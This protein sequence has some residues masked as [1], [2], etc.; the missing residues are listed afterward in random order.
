MNQFIK[1]VLFICRVIYVISSETILY[2]IFRDYSNFI[3][4]ITRNLAA[5]NI[6]YVKVFQAFASNNC[7]IDDETNNQLLKFTDNAPW[8]MDD[9]NLRDINSI[10]YENNLRFNT[11]TELP[12]NTGMISLVFKLYNKDTN[13]PVILK[14]KR[15]QIEEKLIDAICNLQTFMYLLSFFPII[16]K[17]R[18]AELVDKNINIIQHQTNFTEEIDNM[19]RIKNNCKHLKYVKIPCVYK[20]VTVKYP[21][22]ILMEYIDGIKLNEIEEEDYEG[23]AKQVIKFGFVTSII[24]GVTHGDLH[25]GNILFI[26]DN[27]EE[28]YKYKI[29][30]IDFGII[31]DL[32][33]GFRGLLFDVFTNIFNTD[34]K[35]SAVKLLNSGLIDPP[36]ILSQIPKK[37][38]DN[39]I[40]F[41]SK[42]IQETM[43][44]STK[45]NQ[46]QIYKFLS[47]LKDYLSDKDIANIGIRPSDNFVKTQLVL[48][49]SHGVTLTL[50]KSDFASLADK[51]LN[52]LFHTNIAF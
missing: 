17:Y 19:E 40:E 9:I 30:V 11:E 6:L 41:T 34:P 8:T 4:R 38:Y 14:M 22:A 50:C 28:K 42:I 32:G 23:F 3:D 37:H 44:T 36:N 24:H 18:F 26:K 7:L 45:M 31:Y 39:I 29:G 21:N 27:N 48:A 33:D 35:D 2:G 20:D 49:M 12:V 46:I 10:C 1:G 15:N 5:I 16:N 52:E 25:E 43:S 51:V 47:T 13:T